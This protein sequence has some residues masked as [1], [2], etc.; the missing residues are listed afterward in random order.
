MKVARSL[1]ISQAATTSFCFFEYF[2]QTAFPVVSGDGNSEVNGH[3][4]TTKVKYLSSKSSIPSQ[5]LKLT[6]LLII[7]P[8]DTSHSYANPPFTVKMKAEWC[9][10]LF[11]TGA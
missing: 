9:D 3:G 5:L 10:M 7:C 8:D 2:G 1:S 11:T 4:H 6:S